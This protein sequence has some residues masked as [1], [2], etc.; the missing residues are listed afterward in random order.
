MWFEPSDFFP[1]NTIWEVEEI[2]GNYLV[3]Q[4]YRNY[5]SQVIKINIHGDKSCW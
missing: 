1:K 5:L 3:N 4:P 2:K